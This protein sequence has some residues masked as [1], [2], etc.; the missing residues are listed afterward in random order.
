MTAFREA[1][2]EPEMYLATQFLPRSKQNRTIH[3]PCIKR[4][5]TQCWHPQR[6]KCVLKLDSTHN[7]HTRV[8]AN[9]MAIIRDAKHNGQ[10]H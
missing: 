2:R 1:K 3:N 4:K 5:Y 8:S 9:Y 6:H 10:I 7:K